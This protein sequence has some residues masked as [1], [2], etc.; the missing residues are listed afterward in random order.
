[1]Q[2]DSQFSGDSSHLR[3]VMLAAATTIL[4]MTPFLWDSFFAAM[5]VTTMAGL[6]VA[7][8]L[9]LIVV[10]ALYQIYLSKDAKTPT[11]KSEEDDGAL[12]PT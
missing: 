4:G 2:D 6:G 8:I 12:A 11:A 5:A 7:P 3:P 10:P 9:T 1:M